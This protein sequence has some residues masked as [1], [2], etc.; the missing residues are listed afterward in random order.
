MV[1]SY[2]EHYTNESLHSIGTHDVAG[3]YLYKIHTLYV[4]ILYFKM[5]VCQLTIVAMYA[6]VNLFGIASFKD[7]LSRQNPN[8]ELV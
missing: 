5:C 8:C 3:H 1:T 7:G 2:K 4:S 6:N